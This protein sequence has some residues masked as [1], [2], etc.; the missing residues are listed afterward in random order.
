MHHDIVAETEDAVVVSSSLYLDT[1]AGVTPSGVFGASFRPGYGDFWLNPAVLENAE[2]VA[3]DELAVVRM[4]T[5]IA[6]QDYDAVRF[7]Y[8]TDEAVTISM[9]DVDNRPASLLSA[10]RGRGCGDDAPVL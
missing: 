4:P 1:G 8:H 6:D 3:N 7:E 10:H 2:T 9:F 5:T